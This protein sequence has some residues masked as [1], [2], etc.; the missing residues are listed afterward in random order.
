MM[1]PAG[2]TIPP[3][4]EPPNFHP[5]HVLPPAPLEVLP[6]TENRASEEKK[7]KKTRDA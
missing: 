2:V 1:M 6:A 7:K 4:G 3:H 5:S